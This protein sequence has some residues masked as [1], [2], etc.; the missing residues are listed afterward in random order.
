M[1]WRKNGLGEIC[2]PR[3]NWLVAA[4]VP[5]RVELGANSICSCS[6]S[7]VAHR[8]ARAPAEVAHKS[9]PASAGRCRLDV[10]GLCHP[11][12]SIYHF[13]AR[14]RRSVE[15]SN[16]LA[17]GCGF[18]LLP[19]DPETRGGGH[20]RQHA[21]QTAL[22]GFKSDSRRRPGAK[23]GVPSSWRIRN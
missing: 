19:A 16:D 5:G 11:M 3:A 15:S 4:P 18:C 2:I 17:R 9:R 10:G 13:R 1:R 21:K 7:A 20:A 8:P 23:S 14:S 22:E 12:K 6:R